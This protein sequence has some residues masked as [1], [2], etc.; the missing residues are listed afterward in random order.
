M[1]VPGFVLDEVRLEEHA[2]AAR[3]KTAR[4]ASPRA[5]DVGEIDVVARRAGRSADWR[6]GGQ[7]ESL[8]SG[9]ARGTTRCHRCGERQARKKRASR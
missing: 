2:P 3:P 9:T 6:R 5:D 4:S 1:T 8:R 7:D